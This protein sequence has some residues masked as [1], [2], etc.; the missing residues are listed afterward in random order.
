VSPSV[1]TAT[2]ENDDPLP[3]VNFNPA[4]QS[5]LEDT[6]SMLVSVQIP[7]A[8]GL[9][10][11]VPYSV[12][13]TAVQ[14]ADYS[15]LPATQATIPAGST[16]A[17]ITINIVDD[18][19]NENDET[20]ILTMG[21]PT[22]ANKGIT[23]ISTATILDN[24]Q[25]PTVSFTASASSQAEDIGQILITAQLSTISGLDVTVPFTLGGSATLASDFTILPGTQ[26]FIPAGSPSANITITVI[27]D[28]IDEIDET[29][30]LT[31]GTPINA[32][33]GTTT[34]STVTI[35]DND[36]LP[37]VGFVDNSLIEN[38]G[39]LQIFAQL[40]TV[41]GLDITVPFTVSGGS[42]TPTVDYSVSSIP[43]VI[44]AGSLTGSTS[45]TI[46]DDFIYEN[47]ETIILTM[48][49]PINAIPG[50][51]SSAIATIIDDDPLIGL[52][53]FY[54]G[55]HSKRLTIPKTGFPGLLNNDPIDSN[56]SLLLEV[57]VGS[58]PSHGDLRYLNDDGS[59]RYVPVTG[60]VGPDSF[61][62][63]ITN[64][65][66]AE[67]SAPI[68]VTI[69]VFDPTSPHVQWELPVENGMQYEVRCED[70]T[71]DVDASDDINVDR[72]VLSYFDYVTEKE[73]EIEILNEPPYSTI[74]STCQLN[75]AFN[76]INAIAY[77]NSGNNSGYPAF[78][79]LYRYA[80]SVYL[81]TLKK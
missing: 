1:S 67:K 77:D 56:V 42:A 65:A 51:F 24:D 76:Q 16:S 62:Y 4:S 69:N 49:T 12:T 3:T 8:S 72:V 7:I 5:Q 23:N 41:S 33:Q 37:T 71:L 17:V 52:S 11:I 35:L 47:D 36:L 57:P 78:I 80:F 81:P 10:V 54:E 50:F 68:V 63:T 38:G 14:P 60:Y 40:S 61:A 73:V 20:V 75:P 55:E 2:I 53:D 45:I 59:F 43:I 74:F 26:L 70:I 46:V 79:W 6:G 48:G 64:T 58:E 21:T 18:L 15:I 9:D 31:M 19:N 39:I 22:N 28:L 30:I 32:T 44:P 66:N 34:V 29:V 27:D 13:G 25:F